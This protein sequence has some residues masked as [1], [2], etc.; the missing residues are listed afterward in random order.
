M[1]LETQPYPSYWSFQTEGGEKTLHSGVKRLCLHRLQRR[2]FQFFRV[3]E[4][5]RR[6]LVKWSCFSWVKEG[7]RTRTATASFQHHGFA[8]QVTRPA[9]VFSAA[10]GHRHSEGTSLP[11]LSSQRKLQGNR[12]CKPTAQEH[13]HRQGVQPKMC[14]FLRATGVQSGY[15]KH[16]IQ[17]RQYQECI[18]TT[19]LRSVL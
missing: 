15:K 11:R 2:K 7:K 9:E 19:E 17:K 4:K 5:C 13:H 14:A 1:S 12:Q 8:Q 18:K 3:M 6:S 10:G 16:R